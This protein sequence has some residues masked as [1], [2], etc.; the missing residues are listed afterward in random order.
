MGSPDD[1]YT[2]YGCVTLARERL[3]ANVV[4]CYFTSRYL[5]SAVFSVADQ[6]GSGEIIT[7]SQIPN[8]PFIEHSRAFELSS[9]ENGRRVNMVY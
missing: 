1:V 9:E 3:N 8:F 2:G 5:L 7:V 6:S 4:T